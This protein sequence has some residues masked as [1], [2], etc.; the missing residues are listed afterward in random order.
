MISYSGLPLIQ[1]R[2]ESRVGNY[3]AFCRDPTIKP[4]DYLLI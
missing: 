4:W 2:A 1:G 3:P